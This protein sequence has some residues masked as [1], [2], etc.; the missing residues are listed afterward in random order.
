MNSVKIH[1]LERIESFSMLWNASWSV[2][3]SIFWGVKCFHLWQICVL[4][5]LLLDLKMKT[6][7][8]SKISA[9]VYQFKWHDVTKSLSAPLCG[10]ESFN[11]QITVLFPSCNSWWRKAE[12]FVSPA[13]SV[14]RKVWHPLFSFI[15][16]ALLLNSSFYLCP[17]F[18]F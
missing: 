6:Q 10:L 8:S 5:D 14:I 1:K 13:S 16:D 7:C 2:A 12:C 18:W 17:G 11:S 4:L 3:T 15:V 9:T